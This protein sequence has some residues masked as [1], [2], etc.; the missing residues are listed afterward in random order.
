MAHPMDIHVG[1][2]IRQRRWLVGMTQQALASKVGI[3]FQQIQKYET[4]ANRVSASR[5]WEI[6]KVLD[7]PVTYFFDDFSEGSDEKNDDHGLPSDALKSK[8]VV[9]LLRAYLNLP[10]NKR[11]NL[12][13]LARNLDTEG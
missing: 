7:V 11:R 12:L 2:R 4:G 6:S 10:D 13:D 5:I 8:E 1:Q 9:H 3:K